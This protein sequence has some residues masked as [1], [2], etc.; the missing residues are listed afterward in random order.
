MTRRWFPRLYDAIMGMAERGRLA[1]WRR[2]MVRPLRGFVV[3]IGAGTG[4]NFR[5]FSPGVTVVA[6][7]PDLG[8][9]ERAQGR[10][11]S[12]ASPILIVAADARALPFRDKT[13]DA[14]VIGLALCTIPE[15]GHAVRE[16]RRILTRDGVLRA[17]EHVRCENPVLGRLQDLLTPAWR[18]MAGGCRL[19]ER[20]VETVREAGFRI[21]AL[22]WHLAQY[23]VAITATPEGSDP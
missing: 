16:V 4:L 17:L 3:E 10:A 1:G 5:H 20:S 22:R 23:V 14:A 7:E 21:D 9:L 15:P 18:R 19:N 6:T 2:E 13:F 8:M 11:R 12:A